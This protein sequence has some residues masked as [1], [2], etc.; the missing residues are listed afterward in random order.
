MTKQSSSK[1]IAHDICLT[2]QNAGYEA[3]WAGGCV[4]DQYLG[5]HPKDYDI[6]TSAR[7]NQ[8]EA[9]FSKTLAIGKSFGVIAVIEDKIQI[10]V[11]TFRADAPYSDGRHP[12]AVTFC[13]AAE[14]AKRRDFT[15]NALFY[16]PISKKL[17]DYVDGMADLKAGLIR[18]IGTPLER[19]QEDRLRLLRAVRFSHVLSFHIEPSTRQAL[20]QEASMIN[21]VSIERIECELTRTLTESQNPG[22]AL[23]TL[24]T[25]GLLPEILPEVSRLIGVEQP[26]DYHPEGDVYTHTRMMLNQM[27]DVSDDSG[28]TQLEIAY[29]ILLHDISKPDTYALHPDPK[30]GGKR[31]RFLEHEAKGAMKADAILKRLKI[32]NRQRQRIVDVIANH[33]RPFRATQMRHSTLR[34]MMGAPT[35]PLLLE[36]H[37]LDGLGS[38]GLL[39]SYS[40][41][42]KAYHTFKEKPILPKPWISGRDLIARGMKDGPALGRLLSRAYDRQLEEKEPNREA[43]L[44]WLKTHQK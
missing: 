15:I 36:L 31:I 11:A 13:A 18:A 1:A 26:P 41:L 40:F 20:E 39:P 43:L 17:I 35:F 14:D 32:P 6:A 33:M 5:L 34:R 24:Q 8:V 42:H 23:H 44:H 38:R 4:R 25:V 12:D 22:D 7:P 16:D 28:F 9:L 37:R 19:F 2:L 27:K 30:T 3:Y 21:A 10:D 29:A